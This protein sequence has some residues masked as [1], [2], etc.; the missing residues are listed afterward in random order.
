MNSSQMS[1]WLF[2]ASFSLGTL[3]AQGLGSLKRVTPPQ[4]TNVSQY[5]RDPSALVLL[6]KALF[7]DMQ[8][9]SDGR[10]A[11]ASCHFHAGADHRAQNQLSNLS[12]GTV[13]NTLLTENDFP[14]H[15]PSDP[16]N[17]RSPVTR[18]SSAVV[19][20]AG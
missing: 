15:V 3:M 14:F 1:T 10:T 11:C 9:G 16:A 12:A 7:W 4:P 17:N 13:A 8:A 20:S 5:I 19:G 6:G 18:D 2:I